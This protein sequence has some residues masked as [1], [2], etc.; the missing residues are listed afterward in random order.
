MSFRIE[1]IGKTDDAELFFG[2]QALDLF[3]NLSGGHYSN[4]TALARDNQCGGPHTKI[5]KS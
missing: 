5:R 2:I 4:A 1:L 3:D